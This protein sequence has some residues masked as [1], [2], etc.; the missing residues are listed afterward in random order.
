MK[1][2]HPR[3]AANI[4]SCLQYQKRYVEGT[5]RMKLDRV[6]SNSSV[7]IFFWRQLCP[8]LGQQRMSMMKTPIQTSILTLT[9]SEGKMYKEARF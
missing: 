8:E 9:L 3:T 4:F 1:G 5:E 2:G 7:H 6:A